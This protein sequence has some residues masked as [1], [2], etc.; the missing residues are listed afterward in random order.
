MEPSVL[1]EPLIRND[2]GNFMYENIIV[3]KLYSSKSVAIEE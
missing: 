2:N 3:F 1:Y